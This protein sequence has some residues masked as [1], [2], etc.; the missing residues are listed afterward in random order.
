[1]AA[2]VLGAA[3]CLRRFLPTAASRAPRIIQPATFVAGRRYASAGPAPGAVASQPSAAKVAGKKPKSS[4]KAIAKQMEY[5]SDP[6]VLG[7]YIEDLLGKGKFDDAIMTVQ[8]ASKKMDAVVSWNQLIDHQLGKDKIKLAMGVFNDMKKRGQFPNAQT[9]TT[10]F[11]GLAKSQHPKNAVAEAIK[12][13]NLLKNDRRLQP[14]IIHINAILFVCSR[15]Y[16]IDQLFL[17]AGEIDDLKLAPTAATYSCIF[18]AMRSYARNAYRNLDKETEA[19]NIEK[20]L[21][22]GKRIWIEVL[23]KWQKGKLQLDESLICTMGRLQLLDKNRTQKLEVLNLLEQTMNLP[24]LL[25]TRNDKPAA[26]ETS[27]ET[28]VVPKQQQNGRFV[29]PGQNT[30]T[31]VLTTLFSGRKISLAPKYWNLLVND[32][33]VKPDNDNWLRMIGMLKQSKSSAYAAKLVGTLPEKGIDVDARSF[34]IAME[35]CIRDNINPHVMT[36]ATT[37]LH[38]MQAHMDPVPDMQTMRLYLRVALVSHA[39]F[40][41]RATTGD[42]VGAKAAYG[43]QI[44]TALAELWYPYI[45]MYNRCFKSENALAISK[46][47]DK[48]AAAILHTSQKEVIALGRKMVGAFSKVVEEQMLPGNNNRDMIIASAK[49]NKGIMAFFEDR[50]LREPKVSKDS[51]TATAAAKRAQDDGQSVFE[52]DMPDLDDAIDERLAPK[53][54]G[55][56]SGSSKDTVRPAGDFVWNTKNLG[57]GNRATVRASSRDSDKPL[58]D[59]WITTPISKDEVALQEEAKQAEL[60]D[61][62]P[63]TDDAKKNVEESTPENKAAASDSST[64]S[65]AS[66]WAGLMANRR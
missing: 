11:R 41:G 20:L 52:I 36:H 60:A 55:D 19:E 21:D 37:I 59:R 2:R 24:N 28:A 14:N 64:D 3:S 33:K 4:I 54:S 62:Q 38:R 30:L 53:S 12:L 61:I 8:M 40:R 17:I 29:K 63:A 32:L 65:G 16:D 10:M 39:A 23:E 49:I 45:D 27:S 47:A 15:A 50:E 31:V 57:A 26:N 58:I 6:W 18:S 56:S 25:K 22:R 44:A 5:I 48:T 7:K 34:G 46:G 13:F 9:Y 1:M 35:A 43:R 51:A 66:V 42:V